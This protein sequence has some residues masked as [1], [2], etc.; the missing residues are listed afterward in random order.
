MMIELLFDVMDR[1]NTWI[2]SVLTSETWSRQYFKH[3]IEVRTPGKNQTV[4]YGTAFLG[5]AMS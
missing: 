3:R 4:P 1:L 5:V 2:S